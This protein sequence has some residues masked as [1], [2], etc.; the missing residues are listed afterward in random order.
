[1]NEGSKLHKQG[2]T[3]E[4][5]RREERKKETMECK[6]QEEG[7]EACG[8]VVLERRQEGQQAV[9]VDKEGLLHGSRR[10]YMRFLQNST[11]RLGFRFYI[12]LALMLLNFFYYSYES[13]L[14]IEP[15]FSACL[16]KGYIPG[17]RKIF[18][19]LC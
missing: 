3:T 18:A 17:F 12:S 16:E 4:H 1:M 7:G 6:E 14:N 2:I 9:F 15:S 5:E 10:E 8:C 13:F 11:A 19:L